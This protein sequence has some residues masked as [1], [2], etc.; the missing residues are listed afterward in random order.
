VLD[1]FTWATPRGG[2]VWQKS[3]VMS[4]GD[5]FTD[6]GTDICLLVRNDR[7]AGDGDFIWTRTTPFG[8][9]RPLHREFAE[10]IE[11]DATAAPG[12][13]SSF[14]SAVERSTAAQQNNALVIWA[15]EHADALAPAML[16]FANTYGPLTA[17]VAPATGLMTIFPSVPVEDWFYRYPRDV[18]ELPQQFARAAGI[19]P[20]WSTPAF[21][22]SAPNAE[23][24]T[25][26]LAHAAAMYL[27]LRSASVRLTTN[28][29]AEVYRAVERW[30]SGRVVAHLRPPADALAPGA[31]PD[32]LGFRPTDLLGGL[33]LLTARELV[34]LGKSK[35]CLRCK[36][37]FRTDVARGDGRKSRSDRDYCSVECQTT[38]WYAAGGG[39]AKKAAAYQERKNQ[40]LLKTTPKTRKKRKPKS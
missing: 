18:L 6:H 17:L 21:R 39:K 20:D 35:Q 28:E 36:T 11:P 9:G 24:R 8:G 25:V 31:R 32:P 30:L 29:L 12:M 38:H 3:Q 7:Q 13:R 33:W 37:W 10:L 22:S 5:T 1:E 40:G 19:D 15:I 2:F 34:G 27:T 4:W 16:H 26:W 23:T 14:E